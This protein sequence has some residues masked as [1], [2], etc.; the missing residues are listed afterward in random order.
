MY[1][2]CWSKFYK[3]VLEYLSHLYESMFTVLMLFS[4]YLILD[5]ELAL[6]IFIIILR[7]IY[8]FLKTTLLFCYLMT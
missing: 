7:K 4:E 5:N 1:N 6:K 2:F 3:N 8:G